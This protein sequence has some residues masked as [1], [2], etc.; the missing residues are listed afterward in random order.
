M[1]NI[2]HRK[3]DVLYI[4]FLIFITKSE[5]IKETDRLMNKSND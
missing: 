4:V 2:K 1:T 3:K 5:T